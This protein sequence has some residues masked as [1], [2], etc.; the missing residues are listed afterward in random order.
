MKAVIQRVL[1]A[2]VEVDGSRIAEVGSGLLVFLG[3]VRGDGD[4]DARALARKLCSLRLFEDDAAKMNLSLADVGGEL[5]VVSQ[6]T[7]A[8]DCRKGRRPSFDPAAE[9]PEAQRLYER[10]C[11]LCRGEGAAV[12]TGRFAA[13]MEISLVNDGP[14]TILLDSSELRR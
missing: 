11:E 8:A 4:A 3:V 6:F 12:K 13:H 1:R 7:L 10:F 14:V 9:P 5:L 2:A